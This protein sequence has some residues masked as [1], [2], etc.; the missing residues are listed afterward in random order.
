[1]SWRDAR[2]SA[3][4]LDI[5]EARFL[6]LVR[7]GKFP[8]ASYHM[9]ERSPRWNTDA[10]DSAMDRTTVGRDIGE[11]VNDVVAEIQKEAKSRTKAAR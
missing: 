2:R 8:P 3:E 11:A 9:G 6:A 5:S 7:A 4:H 1:M 10:L